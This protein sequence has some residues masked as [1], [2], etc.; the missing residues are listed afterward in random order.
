MTKAHQDAY[1]K[2]VD[3]GQQAWRDG[4]SERDN[5][6]PPEAPYHDGWQQGWE[7]ER[8]LETS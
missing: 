1:Q 3:K 7:I 5:P 2:A 6:Y 8:D 4:K